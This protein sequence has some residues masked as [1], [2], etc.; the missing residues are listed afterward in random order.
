MSDIFFIFRIFLVFTSFFT[1]FLGSAG[2]TIGKDSFG[3]MSHR[4][5]REKIFNL[6]LSAIS[7][8]NTD[9]FSAVSMISY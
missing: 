6:K 8:L 1:V 5:Q 4:D 7:F 9:C 3:K 2:L